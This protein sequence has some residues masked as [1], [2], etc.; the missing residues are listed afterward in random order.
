[1]FTISQMDWNILLWENICIV[2][3]ISLKFTEALIDNTSALVQLMAGAVSQQSN[4]LNN[5]VP[6]LRRYMTSLGYN[7]LT[8]HVYI[9]L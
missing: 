4:A 6:D 1:M 7:E 9:Q 5:I 3:H 2:I 8:L